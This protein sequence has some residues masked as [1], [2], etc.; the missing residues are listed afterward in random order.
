M[1]IMILHTYID[2]ILRELIDKN[3]PVMLGFLLFGD[4]VLRTQKNL[5]YGMILEQRFLVLFRMHLS[6]MIP[7]Y[8]YPYH[9]QGFFDLS[10]HLTDFICPGRYFAMNRKIMFS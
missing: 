5:H 2:Y 9:N 3:Y 8:S 6:G 7:R 4:K 10:N 1:P